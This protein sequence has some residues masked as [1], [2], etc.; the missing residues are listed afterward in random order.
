MGGYPLV[1]LPSGLATLWLGATLWFGHTFFPPTPA[2]KI[3]TLHG[4]TSGCSALSCISE[5]GLQ[6]LISC[7]GLVAAFWSL[8]PKRHLAVLCTKI[9]SF[10]FAVFFRASRPPGISLQRTN[11]QSNTA[12]FLFILRYHTP[13]QDAAST[14]N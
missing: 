12:T 5:A 6:R 9:F 11:R 8:S 14:F 10:Q 13:C 1:W 2:P 3:Q 7:R 4:C